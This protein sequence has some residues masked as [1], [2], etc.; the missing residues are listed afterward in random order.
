MHTCFG[1]SNEHFKMTTKWCHN[2]KYLEDKRIIV[3][4][5]YSHGLVLTSPSLPFNELFELTKYHTAT[6]FLPIAPFY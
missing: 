3:C 2:N 5:A 1:D 6:Q 4:V